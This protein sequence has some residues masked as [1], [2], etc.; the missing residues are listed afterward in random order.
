MD[1]D[2]PVLRGG[3][4][5]QTPRRANPRSKHAGICFRNP[6]PKHRIFMETSMT[7]TKTSELAP[8]IVVPASILEDGSPLVIDLIREFER[9]RRQWDEFQETGVST[10][11]V[12]SYDLC[13]TP[14]LKKH[15]LC[16]QMP[17]VVSVTDL[18]DI[19][20]FIPE[21][22]DRPDNGKSLASHIMDSAWP[23]AGGN[24]Q[25]AEFW[26]AVAFAANIAERLV[27]TPSPSVVGEPIAWLVKI[28]GNDGMLLDTRLEFTKPS[29]RSS[30]KS[31]FIPLFTQSPDSN[32]EARRLSGRS[33]ELD[34]ID[35]MLNEGQGDDDG[36]Q[37]M[38][39]FDPDWSVYAKV[40]ACL[41]L[42]ERRRDVIEGFVSKERR[43][44]DISPVPAAK[45]TAAD[46]TISRALFDQLVRN[47]HPLATA[48]QLGNLEASML[49]EQ[50]EPTSIRSDEVTTGENSSYA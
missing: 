29:I 28:Y 27:P 41:Q 26:W 7:D 2:P 4:A 16:R 24:H 43:L 8:N 22:I 46:V 38:P 3:L 35:A 37:I 31:E 11:A 21:T 12:G 18:A 32:V 34:D 17:A 1:K 47:A 49:V 36:L 10:A 9:A 6:L 15:L 33:K 5:D 13:F 20:S 25:P 50:V 19:L 39:D 40:E 48:D 14:V 30:A 44:N 42:L 45:P 23:M